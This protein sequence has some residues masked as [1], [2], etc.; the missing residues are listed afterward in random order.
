VLSLAVQKLL[1]FFPSSAKRTL[2]NRGRGA[3]LLAVG[4]E[5]GDIDIIKTDSKHP[6]EPRI[7]IFRL[8]VGKLIQ[9][10]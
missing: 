8:F 6:W 4:T 2:G 5:M 1:T 9:H 10:F 3:A 7:S